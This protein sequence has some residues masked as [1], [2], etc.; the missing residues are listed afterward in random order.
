MLVEMRTRGVSTLVHA[1]VIQD[2]LPMLRA[3]YLYLR[4]HLRAPPGTVQ[5]PPAPH[6][7]DPQ[8]VLRTLRPDEVGYMQISDEDVPA[9][10]KLID[11]NMLKDIPHWEWEHIFS[12]M[13][14]IE[15]IP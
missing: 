9:I 6:P 2:E 1:E 14:E 12:F 4:A 5:A 7:V 15:V 13:E 8:D 3:R 11:V 10:R